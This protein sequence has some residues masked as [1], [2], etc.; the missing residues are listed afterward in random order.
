MFS[1]QTEKDRPR[2][3]D[4]VTSAFI[5]TRGRV[6]DRGQAGAEGER[7]MVNGENRFF[8]AIVLL[9]CVFVVQS[10]SP[11]FVSHTP[12]L[13]HGR[14][15]PTKSL[16]LRP[17]ALACTKELPN[18]RGI[19]P[20][21][22]QMCAGDPS[23]IL[24]TN[25]KMGEKKKAFMTAVSQAVA[26]GL[27]K[28][29][30]F[31]AVCVNDGCDMIW[32]GQDVPCALGTLYSLG[33]INLENNKKVTAKITT[34]LDEFGVAPNKMYI[35]FFDVPRENCGYNGATFGG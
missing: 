29:E 7:T 2:P 21:T 3:L 25:V 30:S 14:S 20:A 19:D 10:A 23:I 17:T 31:V 13:L 15:A 16:G 34:L 22:G 12:A 32:G 27:G 5:E 35:N 28:P 26:S 8:A 11:A 6:S 24:H 18:D 4:P 9:E 33:A 1:Y